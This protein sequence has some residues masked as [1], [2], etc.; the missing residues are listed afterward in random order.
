[1]KTS[2]CRKNLTLLLR[3]IETETSYDAASVE[4]DSNGWVTALRDPDKT[5]QAP[6]TMRILVG[7]VADLLTLA[8]GG[9]R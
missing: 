9:A 6:E 7:P 8:K 1:M 2:I 5:Y 4:I 3:Y